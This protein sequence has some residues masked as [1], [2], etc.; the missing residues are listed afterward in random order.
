MEAYVSYMQLNIRASFLLREAAVPSTLCTMDASAAFPD[1][2]PFS[3]LATVDPLCLLGPHSPASPTTN[4]LSFC[5]TRAVPWG[6][7]GSRGQ[8]MISASSQ[9]FV[10]VPKRHAHLQMS[11][12]NYSL[13]YGKSVFVFFQVLCS[14]IQAVIG[15][16]EENETLTNIYGITLLSEKPSPLPPNPEVLLLLTADAQS[17]KCPRHARFYLV[18]MAKSLLS[19][20]GDSQ[21]YANKPLT[22]SP[23]SLPKQ[24]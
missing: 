20:P 9:H 5:S 23:T 8:R 3:R 2:Q 13:N 11:Y 1:W 10:C 22:A 4:S 6:V 16:R 19:F 15:K 14:R 18:P 24:S 12:G 17:H 21:S 7:W